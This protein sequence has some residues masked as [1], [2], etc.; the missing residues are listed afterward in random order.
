MSTTV[1]PLYLLKGAVYALEQ[2][3]LLLRDAN[4]LYRSGSYANAVV[5]AVFAYEELGHWN[6][7]LD[8]RADVLS[9]RVLTAVQVQGYGN[10]HLPKL[11]AGVGPLTFSADQ[12]T[13]LGRLLVTHRTA[14]HGSAE[15]N[16]AATKLEEAGEW[17]LGRIAE[18]RHKLR[19]SALYVDAV[20]IQ[21]WNRPSEK[22]HSDKLTTSF[23]TR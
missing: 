2:C 19:M 4:T 7:L 15:K 11:E 8:L 23:E 3:G 14:E 17:K 22:C 21:E 9:G 6:I 10:D 5:F 12:S 13:G 20:S 16:D 1:S 18:D